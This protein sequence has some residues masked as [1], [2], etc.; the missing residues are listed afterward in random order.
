MV[1]DELGP[2]AIV[3]RTREVRAGGLLGLLRGDRCTELTAST[4]LPALEPWL[5]PS[6][7]MDRG[8][9]LSGPVAF[10]VRSPRTNTPAM[11]ERHLQF[12][13][14]F[15]NGRFRAN[16][17][18][19]IRKSEVEPGFGRLS[20]RPSARNLPA[21]FAGC[22]KWMV[23]RPRLASWVVATPPRWDCSHSP[24]F[25]CAVRSRAERGIRLSVTPFCACAFLPWSAGRP[26]GS[27]KELS[28]KRFTAG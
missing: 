5:R 8:I 17:G 6:G 11:N 4:D 19:K 10:R 3:L 27:R 22:V 7:A 18:R 14:R 15:P 26:V 9:D 20:D 13:R 25:W 24:P 2:D 16:R 21:N 23:A 12:E 28:K 1:R